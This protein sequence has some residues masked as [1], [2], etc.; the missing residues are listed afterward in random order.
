[1]F[2]QPTDDHP[3]DNDDLQLIPEI[4]QRHTPPIPQYI[5]PH[6][7]PIAMDI[8]KI[9]TQNIH[10]LWCQAW[11]PDGN[12]IPRCNRDNTK[13]EHLVHQMRVEEDIHAWLVQ[14]TWL[15]DDDVDTNIGGYHLF[16]HNSLAR[17]IVFMVSQSS[18]CLSISGMESLRVT[19]TNQDGP[20]WKI[21]WSISWPSSRI[22]WPRLSMVMNDG[23]NTLPLSVI[24]LSSLPRHSP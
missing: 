17:T 23:K 7:P 15:E 20:H 12:I 3:T 21:C 11:D 10:G 22:L 19:A 14:K 16:H 1:L 9:Y 24:Y 5:I 13:L 18:S 4:P 8:S 2:E 6:V